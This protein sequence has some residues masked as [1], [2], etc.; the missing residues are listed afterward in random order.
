[1]DKQINN[2]INNVN[3]LTLTV[4]DFH[5]VNDFT[6]NAYSQIIHENLIG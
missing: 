4:D 3:N 1:M 5:S 2:I 6:N